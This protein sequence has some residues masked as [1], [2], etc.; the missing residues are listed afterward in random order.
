MGGVDK[1]DMLISLYRTHIKSNKWTLRLVTHAFDMA[2]TI[3]WLEYSIDANNL[4]IEKKSIMDLILF[5]ER[6]GEELI[7]V[8][9]ICQTSPAVLG[10]K[11]ERPWSVSPLVTSTPQKKCVRL[12]NMPNETMKLDQIGHF[13]MYDKKKHPLFYKR[14]GCKLKSHWVCSKCKVHLCQTF[15]NNC[16]YKYHHK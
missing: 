5:R 9:K 13:A 16:F 1:H 7:T 11:R 6:L 3:S 12:D 4:K 14:P 2:T 10:V 15:N 8:G